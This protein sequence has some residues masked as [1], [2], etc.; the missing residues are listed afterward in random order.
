M[1]YQLKD[2]T[3]SIDEV[4]LLSDVTASIEAGTVTAVIGANGSGK[5]TLLRL[6]AGELLPERGDVT[7]KG[8]SVPALGLEQRARCVSVLPQESHLDFPFLSREVIAM[9]RTPFGD[10][11]VRSEVIDELIDR[12]SLGELASRQY[13]TLSGGEKQ[14]VQIARVL[15]QAWSQLSDNAILLDEPTNMLDLSHELQLFQVLQDTADKGATCVVV[16]H[17]LNLALRFGERLLLLANGRL[18]A[19]G[20]PRE[21]VTAQNLREAFGVDVELIETESGMMI[22]PR[23]P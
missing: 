6:M 13:T 19:Q 2:L 18:L 10:E 3:Y 5:S 21:V 23:L 7:F 17:D 14:R 15:C 4:R 12:L 8:Q 11:P 9:G 20:E 16:L 22:R 1:S